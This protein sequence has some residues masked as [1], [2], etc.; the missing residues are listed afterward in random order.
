[1]DGNIF[2]N[3]GFQEGLYTNGIWDLSFPIN[4]FVLKKNGFGSTT[5]DF[6]SHRESISI[7]IWELISSAVTTGQ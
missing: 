3:S 5:A 7:V 1:M 2:C 6:V 4:P